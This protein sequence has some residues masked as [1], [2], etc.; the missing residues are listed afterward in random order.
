MDKI[1]FG[2][3]VYQHHDAAHPHLHI[4]S[5]NIQEDGRR[6]GVHN[7]GN[8]QSEMTR[9]TISLSHREVKWKTFL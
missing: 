2:G 8:D 7:L 3:L 5:T 1:G 4:V 6:I 9:K